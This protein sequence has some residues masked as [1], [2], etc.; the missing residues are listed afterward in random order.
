[1]LFEA[2]AALIAGA[3]FV[4]VE[5]IFINQLK[6]SNEKSKNQKSC[7]SLFWRT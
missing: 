7:A 6:I 1:M 5:N 3:F 2:A 4:K